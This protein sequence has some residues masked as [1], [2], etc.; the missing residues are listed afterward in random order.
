MKEYHFTL[1]YDNFEAQVALSGNWSLYDFAA[2][3]IKTVGFDFDHCFQF[4]DNLQNP[5]QS[6]ELYTLFADIGQG[7]GEPG[8]QETKISS[9]FLPGKTMLFHF[10]YGD[11]WYFPVTCTAVEESTSKRSFKKVLSTKG[12]PPEQYPDYED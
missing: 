3:L 10:D 7:D 1:K 8:V 5:Y 2:F 9:V 11:D 12:T 6:N 4:C